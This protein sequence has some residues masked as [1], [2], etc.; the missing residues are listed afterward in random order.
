[1]KQGFLV[2]AFLG[3]SGE[4]FSTIM[5][6]ESHQQIRT[7]QKSWEGKIKYKTKRLGGNEQ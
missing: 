4:E 3:E 7:V 5:E 6:L 1:M 2:H